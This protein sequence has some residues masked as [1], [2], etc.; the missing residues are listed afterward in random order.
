[1]KRFF[2]VCCLL[3]A[4]LMIASCV[5]NKTLESPRG[6]VPANL[7]A[8]QIAEAVQDAATSYEWTITKLNDNEFLAEHKHYGKD[9]SAQVKISFEGQNYK[10]DYVSSTGLNYNQEK[11]T[12]HSRYNTWIRNLNKAISDQLRAQA[13]ANRS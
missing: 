8:D 9:L 7:N 4:S 6:N 10:I 12:V 11:N 13:K 5:S 2:K 3:L 1:M